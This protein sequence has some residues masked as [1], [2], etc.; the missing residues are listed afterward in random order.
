MNPFTLGKYMN[1]DD[2]RRAVHERCPNTRFYFSKFLR[3]VDLAEIT[4]A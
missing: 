4:G 3:E 1:L 2:Y